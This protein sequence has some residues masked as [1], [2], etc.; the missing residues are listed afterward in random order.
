M[1]HERAAAAARCGTE[2]SRWAMLGDDPVY[3]STTKP[4]VRTLSPTR[5]RAR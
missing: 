4:V 5:S 3:R 2:T 1:H